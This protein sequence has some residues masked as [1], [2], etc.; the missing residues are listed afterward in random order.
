MAEPPSTAQSVGT[1]VAAYAATT[2]VSVLPVLI[3]NPKRYDRPKWEMVLRKA[4]AASRQNVRLALLP[5]VL[6]LV[7]RT[8]HQFLARRKEELDD[9]S[10][11][12]NQHLRS[13]KKLYNVLPAL[14][15]SPL[16]ILLPENFRVQVA[17]Y[18]LSSFLYTFVRLKARPQVKFEEDGD[19]R[20]GEGGKKA[21][22]QRSRKEVLENWRDYLPPVWTVSVVANT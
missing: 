22:W 9:P 13:V 5:V 1:F 20:C 14:L 18:F 17:L 16:F 2:T 8:A 19:R 6:P 10:L 7:Y 4:L 3:V 12:G 11:P 21:V 15:S